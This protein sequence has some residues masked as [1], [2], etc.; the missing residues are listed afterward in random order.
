MK[1]SEVISQVKKLYPNIFTDSELLNWCYAVTCTIR[2]R[3]KGI[4]ERATFKGGGDIAL[5]PLVL[6]EDIERVLVNGKEIQKTDETSF[7]Y[8]IEELTDKDTIEVI[9]R[10][11]PEPYGETE[12][13]GYT[14]S[15]N[16]LSFD[17]EAPIYVYPSDRLRFT[18]SDGTEKIL[19]VSDKSGNVITL[20]DSP[21]EN[22]S[23]IT[24]VMEDETE[25]P[26]PFAEM[27]IQYALAK[28]GFHQNNVDMYNKHM[29]V[30][31]SLLNDYATWYKRTNPI[32]ST[33][34][35]NMW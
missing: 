15:G 25:V 33:Q 10:V 18:Y 19:Y 26:P 14:V 22:V 4:Y 31:N 2:E 34:F 27:Y 17:G 35:K 21:G 11:R 30:Y 12:L 8:A 16:V 32:K 20:S 5:S 29:S 6:F 13:E 9:Y 1:I 24:T 3:Y 28:I 23:S 7:I